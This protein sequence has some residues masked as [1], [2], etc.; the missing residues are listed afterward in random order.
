M[1]MYLSWLKFIGKGDP[2]YIGADLQLTGLSL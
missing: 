1:Y 2:S